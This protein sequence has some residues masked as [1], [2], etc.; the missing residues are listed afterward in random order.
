MNRVVLAAGGRPSE[1]VVRV[2]LHEKSK[3]AWRLV[4]PYW[5][6]TAWWVMLAI[7]VG[8]LGLDIDARFGGFIYGT[9]GWAREHILARY[10]SVAFILGMLACYY[11]VL[12]RAGF[13]DGE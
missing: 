4:R 11:L 1:E 9:I 7:S 8:V 6:R 12:R 10:P 2:P 5:H 13:K 3:M